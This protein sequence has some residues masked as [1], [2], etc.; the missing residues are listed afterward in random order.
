MIGPHLVTTPAVPALC[1]R[2]RHLTLTGL[3]EGL[4]AR[5]DPTEL[6]P[7]GEVAAILTGRATYTLTPAGELV[8]RDASRITGGLTGVILPEHDCP[9]AASDKPP[10]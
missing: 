3:A 10:Y 7:A 8:H 4:T 2:C 9:H 1:P 6:D 5:V